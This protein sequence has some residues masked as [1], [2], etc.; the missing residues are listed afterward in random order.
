MNPNRIIVLSNEVESKEEINIVVQLFEAGLC[1]FH[2]RKPKFEQTKYNDWLTKLPRKYHNRIVLHDHYVLAKEFNLAGVHLTERSRANLS[3]SA[4]QQKIKDFQASG[5]LVSAAIHELADLNILGDC[6]DYVLVSPVF[7]SISKVGY[8]ANPNLTVQNWKTK[9]A[10]LIALGGI[11]K[12]TVALALAK[13]FDGIAALGYI[14]QVPENA[15]ARFQALQ[16]IY[17][18]LS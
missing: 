13:G 8:L 11:R 2:L 7:D 6:C 9:K 5:L 12:E 4:I 18:S 17:T 10:Q 14:W 3:S 15:L 1:R 16:Q